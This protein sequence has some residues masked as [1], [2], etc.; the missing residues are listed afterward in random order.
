MQKTYMAKPQDAQ[1]QWW[2]VDADG[3]PMSDWD[4]RSALSMVLTHIG[5]E[6]VGAPPSVVLLINGEEEETR[7][8]LPTPGDDAAWQIR[9]VSAARDFRPIADNRWL[10]PGRSIV[11]VALEEDPALSGKE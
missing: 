8:T 1:P 4:G 6:R 5:E 11:C 3:Q 10:L 9:F 7:F 2:V